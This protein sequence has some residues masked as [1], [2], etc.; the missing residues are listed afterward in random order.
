ME[1][2]NKRRLKEEKEVDISTPVTLEEYDKN[3]YVCMDRFLYVGFT[4]SCTA[5]RLRALAHNKSQQTR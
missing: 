3:C 4:D 5:L 1:Y 2:L